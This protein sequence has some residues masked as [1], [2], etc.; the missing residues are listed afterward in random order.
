MSTYRIPSNELDARLVGSIGETAFCAHNSPSRNM[1]GSKQIAQR[2]VIL[3]SDRPIISSGAD[4]AMAST[5]NVSFPCDCT[6]EHIFQRKRVRAGGEEYF[7]Y[8]VVFRNMDTGEYDALEL[9]PN[10]VEHPQFGY[11]YKRTPA[12]EALM[13]GKSVFKKD[14]V[15]LESPNVKP[16][17]MYGQG[18]ILNAV[19]CDHPCTTNDGIGISSDVPELF[20]HSTFIKHTIGY[21]DD[22]VLL[23]LHGNATMY[24]G[25]PDVGEVIGEDQLVCATRQY[26]DNALLMMSAKALCK[27]D[28]VHDQPYKAP[29]GSVVTDVFIIKAPKQGDRSFTGMSDQVARYVAEDQHYYHKLIEW[30][31]RTVAP[32]HASNN[33]PRGQLGHRLHCLIRDA[34]VMTS[35][36]VQFQKQQKALPEYTLEIRL[37]H[38]YVPMLGAKFSGLGH[39]NKGVV[40][41]IFD[42]ETMPVDKYGNRAQVFLSKDSAVGRAIP[43][44]LLEA[45]FGGSV[46][47]VYREIGESL[48]VETKDKS[49]VLKALNA[50]SQTDWQ[51]L[52]TTLSEYYNHV[53]HAMKDWWDSCTDAEKKEE[54]ANSLT[55]RPLLFMPIDRQNDVVEDIQWMCKHLNLTYDKVLLTING[56]KRFSREPVGIY[57]VMMTMLEK[58]ASKMTAC[59]STQFAVSGVPRAKTPD[60]RST[61]VTNGTTR[62]L[63]EATVRINSGYDAGQK[64][65]Q[66]M[67]TE[68]L[69][70]WQHYRKLGHKRY[71]PG[72]MV[73]ELLSRANSMQIQHLLV[74]SILES[75]DPIVK[76]TH[77]DRD[78]YPYANTR[79][80]SMMAAVDIARGVKTIYTAPETYEDVYG[81]KEDPFYG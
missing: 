59:A 76:Q 25:F 38:D 63:C 75:D 23:N 8:V 21:G 45:F 27:Y 46:R 20:K 28:P 42:P 68:S 69:P 35:T 54:I 39:G 1:M 2:P 32:N 13:S 62:V 56:E 18:R 64:S 49:S 70:G 80:L 57:P 71:K 52:V 6:I 55:G 77:V 81:Q 22:T 79:P 5:F 65:R 41:E 31:D 74:K 34:Y 30:Y 9:T 44:C 60:G 66:L 50:M 7:K 51:Y 53:A 24:R 43:G 78:Q 17:G 58:T 3:S 61:T 67:L 47:D 12:F 14:T 11:V 19:F 10:F 16:D 4:V 72:T 29:P 15:L 73:V 40:V 37:R 36:N 33:I 48:A 26:D